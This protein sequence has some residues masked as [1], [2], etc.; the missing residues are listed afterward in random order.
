MSTRGTRGK[1]TTGGRTTSSNDAGNDAASTAASEDYRFNATAKA[2]A[3][4]AAP[5]TS[6]A[7][8]TIPLDPSAGRKASTDLVTQQ[9]LALL[10]TQFLST[11]RNFTDV[12]I[13][14]SQDADMLAL[15][16]S[17]FDS[18]LALIGL[19]EPHVSGS[20]ECKTKFGELEVACFKIA[21][22]C[23]PQPWAQRYAT[24]YR[25]GAS[26]TAIAAAQER[27]DFGPFEEL[28]AVLAEPFVEHPGYADYENP[29][30]PEER[31]LRTFCGT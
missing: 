4:A 9:Q 18:G 23:G 14:I 15:A 11:A 8:A 27:D 6:L 5:A 24:N 20:R 13:D 3:P 16:K 19:L 21:S 26:S 12:D 30:K 1:T 10:A 28:L 2:A 29:P 7:S 31:V 22:K 17:R 25:S